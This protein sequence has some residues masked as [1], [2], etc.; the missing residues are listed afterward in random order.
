MI[1]LRRDQAEFLADDHE[2]EVERPGRLQLRGNEPGQLYFDFVTV[3]P[4]SHVHF[5]IAIILRKAL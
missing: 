3:C 2:R 5:Y 4:R 1:L